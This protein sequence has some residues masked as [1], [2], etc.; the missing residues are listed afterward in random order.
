AL[1]DR[2]SHLHMS[3]P[4]CANR[5]IVPHVFVADV[6]STNPGCLSVHDNNLAMIAKV[7]LPTIRATLRRVKPPHV[8]ACVTKLNEGTFDQVR[9]ADLIV[10][11]VDTNSLPRLFYQ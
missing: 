9:T 2:A 10:N 1:H 3:I 6:Q 11:Y 7:Q 4:P 8:N 5:R